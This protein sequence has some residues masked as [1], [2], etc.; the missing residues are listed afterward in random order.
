[1]E[2]KSLACLGALALVLAP[3]M[4]LCADDISDGAAL[5]KSNDCLSCHAVNRKVVGPAYMDVAKK[6]HGASEA[7]IQT[8]VK[9]VKSG[10]SG[11]WGAVPMAAHPTVPDADLEKM[12]KWVLSRTPANIAADAAAA[13]AAQPTPAP[14]VA[15]APGG[16]PAAAAPVKKAHHDS[17]LKSEDTEAPLAFDSDAH[18]RDLMEKQGCYGCHSGTRRDG[19]ADEMPWP[20]FAKLE[21]KYK[22]AK[23]IEPIVKKVRLNEGK[24][25][26]GTVP[27]PTYEDLPEGAVQAMVA[28]IVSGKATQGVAVVDP[29]AMPAEEWMRK[30]ADCFSCHSVNNKVV[31]PAYRDVAKRYAGASDAQI[32][33][34]VKKVRE[35]GSGNWG[36]V[37][38]A[39]H[40]NATDAQ[41]EKAVRWVLS[42]K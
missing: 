41:L 35:G 25:K 12:V 3:P 20:S 2:L 4:A 26:W 17:Y 29:N 9:K 15:P 23:D 13:A 8:L 24:E 31:G 36:N 19:M 28:Y 6:Y 16:A 42:Q 14:T 10:G 11:N 18:V 34:L 27:H 7:Q 21:A 40:P 1:M 39:A 22:N 37:P 30:A 5:V 38:M 33:V 32:K